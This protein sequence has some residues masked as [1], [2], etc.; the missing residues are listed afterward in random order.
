MCADCHSTGL[1]KQYDATSDRFASSWAEINVGCE[2]CHGPGSAHIAWAKAP[3]QASAGLTAQFHERRGVHWKLDA[4]SGNAARSTP[5]TTS[6]E[7]DVCAQCHARR[8]QIAEGYQ[9]GKPWLDFYRPTLLEAPEYYPDGQQRGEVYVW[10]SF[11]QSKM[12][13][14]GVT[15]SDCHDPHSQKLIAT[16]NTLCAQCHAATKYDTPK[17]HFHVNGQGGPACVDCHMPSRTYMGVDDRRDHSF[18]VPRPDES[19]AYGTPNACN[20]CHAKQAP[21]WAAAAIQRWYGQPPQ[22]F[23]RFASAFAPAQRDI[24][25]TTSRLVTL[26]GDQAAPALVRATALALLAERPD[27]SAARAVSLALNDSSPLVRR[28]A[29]LAI[30]GLPTQQRA[31]LGRPM[32]SDPSRLVRLAAADALAGLPAQALDPSGQQALGAALAESEAS[33]KFSADRPESRT[34][35]GTLLAKQGRVEDATREFEQALV[36]DPAYV[37]AYVNWADTAR[38][39]GDEAAAERVLREGLRRTAGNPALRHALGLK[40]AREKRLPDALRELEAAALAAPENPRFGYVYAVA[41]QSAG[42]LR[43]ARAAL[44]RAL[45]RAPE[46]RELLIAAAEYAR[47]AGDIHAQRGFADRVLRAYPGDREAANWAASAGVAP[48]NAPGP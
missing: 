47:A 41:L 8:E 7:I 36:L 32:L 18:R 14:K 40:L 16:G 29:V 48:G 15:C 10:G 35:Y 19:I 44:D 20:D 45:Q 6:S 2:A 33:L 11:Q 27:A 43:D 22:G 24:A 37:P 38:A 12:N 17:H 13:A 25:Q 9:P 26:S 1:R 39:A 4:I 31:T 21:R 5:R 34:N 42:R 46:D 23:Q 30:E 28:H 3:G